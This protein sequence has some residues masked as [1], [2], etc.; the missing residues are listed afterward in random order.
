MHSLLRGSERTKKV[1]FHF[2]W[3]KEKE[4]ERDAQRKYS[5]ADISGW[6]R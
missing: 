4:R 1:F 6:R 3:W 2:K 5:V